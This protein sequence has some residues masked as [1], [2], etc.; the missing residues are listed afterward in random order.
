MSNVAQPPTPARWLQVKAAMRDAATGRC[1]RWFA[2]ERIRAW[3]THIDIYAKMAKTHVEEDIYGRVVA[4][5]VGPE[6]EL[7]AEPRLLLRL[8]GES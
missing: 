7:R 1:S 6:T 2:E 3:F 8:F 4:V 5:W